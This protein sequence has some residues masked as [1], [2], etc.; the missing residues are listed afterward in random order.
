MPSCD[1]DRIDKLATYVSRILKGANVAE[2]PAELPRSFEFA[3]HLQT[4]Q[5]LGL[6]IRPDVSS[7]GD[8][9]DTVTRG[10]AEDDS[11]GGRE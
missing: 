10:S 6:A 1:R 2:Q 3:L 5:T 11:V 7:Q 8:R 4:A 9:V